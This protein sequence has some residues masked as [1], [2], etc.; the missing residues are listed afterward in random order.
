M[1][2]IVPFEGNNVSAV[3]AGLF[4]LEKLGSVT[5]GYPIISIKGLCKIETRTVFL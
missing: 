5:G 1:N 4:P 2:Q 3:F